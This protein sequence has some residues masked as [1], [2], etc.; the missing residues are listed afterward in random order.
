MGRKSK[1]KMQIKMSGTDGTGEITISPEASLDVEISLENEPDP[2]QTAKLLKKAKSFFNRVQ[3]YFC[4]YKLIN[5]ILVP[6]PPGKR[7]MTNG[8]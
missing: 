8:N 7:R 4:Y 5:G 2:Y 3:D 6:P 1:L